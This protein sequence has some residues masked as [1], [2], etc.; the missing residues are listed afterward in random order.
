VSGASFLKNSC[1]NEL[2]FGWICASLFM[3]LRKYWSCTSP[4]WTQPN[5]LTRSKTLLTLPHPIFSTFAGAHILTQSQPAK[6]LKM[7]KHY[8]PPNSLLVIKCH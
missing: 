2:I 4:Y 5:W 7:P 3:L 8:Q 6:E 1:A